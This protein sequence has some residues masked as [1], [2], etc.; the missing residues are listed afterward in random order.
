MLKNWVTQ[1]VRGGKLWSQK[2]CGQNFL[3]EDIEKLSENQYLL[4][5]KNIHQNFSHNNLSMI[6]KIKLPMNKF[7]TNRARPLFSVLGLLATC[8]CRPFFFP[9]RSLLECRGL[10]KELFEIKFIHI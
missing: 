3:F 6:S 1:P 9:H 10:M 4:F 5:L 2:K 7:V 8:R